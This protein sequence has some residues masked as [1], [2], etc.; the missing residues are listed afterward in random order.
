MIQ[1]QYQPKAGA[2][3][4]KAYLLN[5]HRTLTIMLA[6]AFIPVAAVAQYPGGG[7]APSYG[8]KGALIGGV[9]AGA[10]VGAGLLYWTLHKQ[11]RIEG[12]VTG[13]GDKLVVKNTKQTYN[14]TNKRNQSLK[15]G[16]HVELLG[17]KVK[18]AMG[19][20]TFE[21]RKLNKELGQCRTT[22]AATVRTDR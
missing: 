11:T 17:K 22:S 10:A 7:P 8:S 6:M 21:V 16:E 9:A 20:A 14:L 5:A 2:R 19:E 18:S 1:T 12:C 13:D 3:V 15:P 4:S